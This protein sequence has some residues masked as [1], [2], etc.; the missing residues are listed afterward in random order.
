M[1]KSVLPF[2]KIFLVSKPCA[3]SITATAIT[4]VVTAA[5]SIF[6]LLCFMLVVSVT[7]SFC[8]F[9]FW[10]WID[11]REERQIDTFTENEWQRNYSVSNHLQ[12]PMLSSNFNCV[13]PLH[14]VHAHLHSTSQW[15]LSCDLIN[16]SKRSILFICLDFKI[17]K[18]CVY[19]HIGRSPNWFFKNTLSKLRR[20][21][22]SINA[23]CGMANS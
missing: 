17:H 14:C 20:D 22:I 4:V 12:E 8:S 10:R 6:R 16:S 2:S 11:G 23:K 3:A 9:H 21:H 5:V 13:C 7:G 18:I 1:R 15:F 19:F